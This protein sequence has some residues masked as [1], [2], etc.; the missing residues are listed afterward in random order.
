MVCRLMADAENS[1]PHNSS[2]MALTL[3]VETPCTYVSGSAP[4]ERL[5]APLIPLEP[6]FESAVGGPAEPFVPAC[7][8][9][10]QSAVIVTRSIT[11]PIRRA[12]AFFGSDRLLHL[13]LNGYDLLNQSP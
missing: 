10:S 11:E 6:R 7:R 8:R 9:A 13:G 2:V 5:F 3:R 12:L 1:C 4:T